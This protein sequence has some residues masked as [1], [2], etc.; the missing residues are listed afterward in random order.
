MSHRSW[1]REYHDWN[2]TQ[3]KIKRSGSIFRKL[4]RQI[5]SKFSGGQPKDEVECYT[6]TGDVKYHLGTSY[7]RLTRGGKRIHLSLAANPS[8]LELVNPTVLEKTRTKQYFS[9]DLDRSKNMGILIHGDGSF[10]G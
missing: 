8:H 2:G 3:G 1:R 7:D 10:A 4:I 9:N 6:G 5:F